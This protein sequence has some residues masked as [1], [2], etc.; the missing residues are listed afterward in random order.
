M[1]SQIGDA[2]FSFLFGWWGF[3]WGFLVTPIQ[4]VRNI[5]GAMSSPDETR[6]SEKLR[7]I[8]RLSIASNFLAEQ[9][10]KAA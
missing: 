3:P 10:K 8:V 5:A 2:I 7:H 9:Q 6:P 1:K 4:V